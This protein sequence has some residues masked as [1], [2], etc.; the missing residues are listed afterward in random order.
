MPEGVR[1]LVDPLGKR[2]LLLDAEVLR[3]AD[4]AEG[5]VE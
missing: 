2:P 3:A 1:A 4:G 5:G